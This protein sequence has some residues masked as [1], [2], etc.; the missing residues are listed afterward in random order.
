M[1]DRPFA[2][3]IGAGATVGHYAIM[4]TLGKGGMGE[5]FLAHDTK[6]DRR[7]A[8][9]VLPA[10]FASD[11]S[12]LKR[13]EVEAK[14][15][16]GLSHPNIV[17]VFAIEETAGRLVL[18]MELVDGK[19]LRQYI[20]PQGMAIVQ[21]LE[22]ALSLADAIGAAHARGVLHRDLKPENIMVTASGWVKILDFGLAKFR[23]TDAAD[24]N[25][26]TQ[27]E[28]NL[29]GDG[30]AMGT[31]PYMSPE[32]VDAELVD[33]RSDIF[34][35]GVV[36]HEM[37]TGVPPF[38]GRT[39]AQVLT[40]IL[41]DEP[42]KLSAVREDLPPELCDI[43][44]RCLRKNVAERFSSAVELHK[45]LRQVLRTIDAGAA[46]TRP[47]RAAVVSAAPPG[48]ADER[49]DDALFGSPW[50]WLDSRWGLTTIIAGLW[51]VNWIETNAEEMWSVR[52]SSW[53][54]YD[55][56]RAL[57][58]LEGGL[59]FERQ[60][61]A[62]P[63]AVYLGSIAYFF[64]PILL[65]AFT[66]LALVPRRSRD[67]YRIFAF[68]VCVCYALS[69]PFYMWFPAPERWAYP[70]SQAILLSDLWSVRLIET[71]RPISGL[72]NCFPSFHV[73]GTFALV[74]VWYVLRLRYR[75]AIACLGA[76]VALSTFLL[77]I[78]WVADI[79]AGL[80]V[81]MISVPVALWMNQRARTRL[82]G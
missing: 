9:K 18:V 63:L 5:V 27:S 3:E 4:S 74:Y 81:A 62:S 17:S 61:L 19:T 58:W 40:A 25:N 41:R 23:T 70:D 38:R 10:K 28:I 59:S 68:A 73:S 67:G 30:C 55:I 45:A 42:P 54:G 48:W 77:G 72:D 64:V 31:A 51:V 52:D 50:K 29:T 47:G 46:P 39:T 11:T 8:L 36:F 32:Q 66:L 7:V 14:A 56:A 20:Q 13:F 15:L 44:S 16:A 60:D 33:H 49:G 76:A 2:P 57:W 82:A 71:I 1:S 75:H 21:F 24:G 65:F 53:V 78:H 34:S 79:I 12:R 37:L 6:L 35:L 22:I 69:V 26:A 80:A 43:L